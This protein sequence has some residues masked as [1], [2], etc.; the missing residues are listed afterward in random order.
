MMPERRIAVSGAMLQSD[1]MEN[2][3]AHKIL[4]FLFATVRNQNRLR[5]KV[6]AVEVVQL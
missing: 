5:R 3:V 1:A 6:I 2:A 4:A